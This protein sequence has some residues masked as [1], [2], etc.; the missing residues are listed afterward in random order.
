MCPVFLLCFYESPL[1]SPILAAK[2]ELYQ[3]T[4]ST[5]FVISGNIKLSDCQ[6]VTR[7]IRMIAAIALT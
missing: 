3:Q 4:G 7:D 2:M 5:P 6:K 1:F